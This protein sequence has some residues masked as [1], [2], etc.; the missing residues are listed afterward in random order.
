MLSQCGALGGE[1]LSCGESGSCAAVSG[2]L[3]RSDGGFFNPCPRYKKYG[4]RCSSCWLVPRK[5]VQPK[6]LCGR[7]GLS[8]GPHQG[9]TQEG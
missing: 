7:C 3:L 9:S 4:T 2:L 5:S 1:T 6:K 8:L